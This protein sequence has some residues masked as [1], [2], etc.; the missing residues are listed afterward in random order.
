ME[1]PVAYGKVISSSFDWICHPQ[2]KT[3][4]RMEVRVMYSSNIL[5]C[6]V[7]VNCRWRLVEST[8]I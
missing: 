1:L 5:W 8:Q 6:S 7:N 4:P 3:N 2:W